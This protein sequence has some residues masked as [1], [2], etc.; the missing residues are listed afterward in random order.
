MAHSWSVL[1]FIQVP[2]GGQGLRIKIRFP[3]DGKDERNS[4]RDRGL[5]RAS[6]WEPHDI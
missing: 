4:N 3:D 1:S 6:G 5:L 2:G